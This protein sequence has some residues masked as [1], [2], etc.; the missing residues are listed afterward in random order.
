MSR[1]WLLCAALLLPRPALSEGV[2][3]RAKALAEAALRRQRTSD[4]A[5]RSVS[6]MLD[7]LRAS[8]TELESLRQTAHAP[9]QACLEPIAGMR[10]RIREAQQA[11]LDLEFALALEDE[12][13]ASAA[14]DRV[15]GALSRVSEL[16]G[17][18][19]A[20]VERA[21][22][23]APF[24]PWSTLPAVSVSTTTP[25]VELDAPWPPK[26]PQTGPA[27]LVHP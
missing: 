7:E 21:R 13:Q 27:I 20:C 18:L 9:A 1:R 5:A 3:T 16:G 10:T 24:T 4:R 15:Q 8:L 26:P 23:Q 22:E 12:A 25:S 17:R 11:H 6:A 2:P 14:L 19:H